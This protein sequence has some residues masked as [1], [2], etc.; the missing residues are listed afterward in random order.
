KQY[1]FSVLVPSEVFPDAARPSETDQTR[2]FTPHGETTLSVLVHPNSSE[3]TLNQLYQEW[4]AEHT[5]AEPNRKVH[6][7][8]FRG[9]WFVVSGT[10]GQKGER[11]F[12]V[13]AVRK[14]NIVVMMLLEYDEDA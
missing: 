3:S 2:F 5:R 1:G 7:K 9:N 8:P 10:N 11:G 13:K 4:T 12:Y 14:G 6:Y